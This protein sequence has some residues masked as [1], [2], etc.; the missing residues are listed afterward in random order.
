MSQI[1]LS[2]MEWREEANKNKIDI[3]SLCLLQEIEKALSK[4]IFEEKTEG[5]LTDG[6][7]TF[8]ENLTKYLQTEFNET[9]GGDGEKKSVYKII[10]QDIC[11]TFKHKSRQRRKNKKYHKNRGKNRHKTMIRTKLTAKCWP[12][13][14]RVPPG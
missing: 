7:L 12:K 4:N 3:N 11:Y 13:T 6:P 14:S 9:I 2:E 8:I 1:D 10:D 5:D